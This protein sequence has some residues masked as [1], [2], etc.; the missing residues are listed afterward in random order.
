MKT[1]LRLML[2]VLAVPILALGALLLWATVTDFAPP[3]ETELQATT[4]VPALTDSIFE[5][6]TWNIGYAGLGADVDFFFDGGKMVHG[7]LEQLQRNKAAIYAWMAQHPEIDFFLLQ[8]VDAKAKRTYYLD[9]FAE[10][11]TQLPDY[12]GFFATNYLVDFVPQPLL[13][14]MGEVHSGMASFSK[15]PVER[16]LRVAF[17]GNY[18]WPKSVF[19]LDRCFVPIYLPLPNGKHLVVINTHN[20]AYD[21]GSLKQQQN[22]QLRDFLLAEAQKGNPVIV[23]GDWN[24]MPPEHQAQFENLVQA[25]FNTNYLDKNLVPGWS[26]VHDPTVP[27]NRELNKPYTEAKTFGRVLD[28]FLVSP[29]FEVLECRTFDLQFE[30]SDHHPVYIKLR[31][32]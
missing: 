20:E 18:P 3:L 32:N 5:L 14:P 7:S 21:D 13:E 16:S 12:H 30:H 25:T 10:I 8:E 19:M 17:Q 28:F 29:H 23:G 27:T 15:Y 22:E 6:V 26:F 1:L 9:Q 4:P 24:Q 31:L 11:K 2:L